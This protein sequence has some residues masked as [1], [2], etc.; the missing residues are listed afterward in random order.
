MTE[1]V[2]PK[3]CAVYTRK[4]TDEGLEQAFNSLHAQREACEA[5]IKSQRHEGWRVIETEYDDGGFSGGTMDRPAL[6]RLL[7]DVKAERVDVVVVYKVDRLSR[8]L[9]DFTRVMEL[10]ERHAVSFVSVTQHFN[11]ATS[12]GRLTLNV[13]LSFAQFEREVTGERIRDKIAASKQKGLW[14]GGT[15]PLGYDVVDKNLVVNKTEARIVRRI[16]ERYLTLGC[17]RK[18]KAELDARGIVSK[19]RVTED[20]QPAGGRPFSRGALYTILK[21]PLY[22]GKTRHKGKLYDAQ[23]EPILDPE[24]WE[25]VQARLA[26]N[27]HHHKN[28]GAAKEPSLLSGLLFDDRG[29]PMSPTHTHKQGRRYRYYLSQALLQFREQEAGSVTRLPAREIET[30]VV[31]RLCKLLSSPQDLHAA[32][33]LKIPA[34][35]QKPMLAKARTIAEDWDGT[36]PNE[37]ILLLKSM[38]HQITVGQNEIRIEISRNGLAEVLDLATLLS[39]SRERCHTNN[40]HA[41]TLPARLRRCGMELRLIVPAGEPPAANE[42]AVRTLQTALARALEWNQ[43]LLEGRARSMAHIASQEGVTQRYVARMLRMALLSPEHIEMILAREIPIDVNIDGFRSEIPA[44]WQEQT[45]FPGHIASRPL[46]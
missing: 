37:Q 46:I 32:L 4:S 18:L 7:D 34:H 35:Q 41:L 43:A 39:P 44:N 16:H 1:K 6:T 33:D 10:F 24:I 36:S 22:I 19:K 27:R 21:N 26:E 42:T 25:Q 40:V 14:M 38:V 13:L 29:N 2:T 28:G 9:A 23:H 3:Y 31:E 15:I 20:G 8:S 5:Y 30:P 45:T 11:T 12:M 17:V